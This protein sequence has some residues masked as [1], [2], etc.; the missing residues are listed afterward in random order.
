MPRAW[1]IQPLGLSNQGNK[2]DEDGLGRL[3]PRGSWNAKLVHVDNGQ[4]DAP[5]RRTLFGSIQRRATNE[6]AAESTYCDL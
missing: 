3:R 1:R 6:G 5:A 4:R 2:S